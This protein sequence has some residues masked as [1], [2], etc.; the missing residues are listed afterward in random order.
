MIKKILKK[1]IPQLL[2]DTL[3]WQHSF[4]AITKHRLYAHYKNPNATDND[5]VL[6]LAYMDNELVGYMGIFID[7]ITI[8]NSTEKIGWLSTWWVHPKTKGK[9]IGRNILH[10]MYN[11]MDG[12]IG[13]SQFT[14][15]AKRVY[16]KSGYFNTLK[17]NNGYKFAFRSNSSVVLPLINSGFTKF[18][19]LLHFADNCVNTLVNLKLALH[20]YAIQPKLKHTQIEYVNHIDFELEAFIKQHST[21]HLSQKSPAFFEW[22]KAYH[23]VQETPLKPF[24]AHTNYEFS[25]NAEKFNIYLIKV[26]E[27]NEIVGFIVLQRKNSLSKVLF[28]Y[29]KKHAE[30]TIARFLI[31]H[32]IKLNVKELVCY[33]S[34]INKH[35]IASSSYLYKRKKLKESLISKVF[36]EN[37]YTNYH[38]N[39][40]DGDCC[41]A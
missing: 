11:A 22:L 39:F 17:L 32:I 21:T 31:L 24:T 10:T 28:V 15:S 26:I 9:G 37:N 16:M 19:P 2:N 25:M 35:I 4:L 30:K 33:N 36:K 5:V 34:T 40:G 3:F 6:L 14:P 7:S 1:D 38:F 29:H 8:T 18:K 20:K 23:W 12:K 27:N 41:F 13:V